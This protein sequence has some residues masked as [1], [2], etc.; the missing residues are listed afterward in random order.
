MDSVLNFFDAYKSHGGNWDVTAFSSYGSG[1][2]IPGIVNNMA[3][4]KSRYNKPVMQVEFGGNVNQGAKVKSDLEA[5]IKGVKGFGGLGVFFWEPEG[6]APFTSY[7]M[8]AWNATNKE[9]T[10]AL[11]GFIGT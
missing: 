6:Y 5:Y 2:E 11:S 8:G 7:Q 10:S 3:T 1:N 4:V 9:P